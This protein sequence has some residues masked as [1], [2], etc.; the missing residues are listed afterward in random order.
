MIIKLLPQLAAPNMRMKAGLDFFNDQTMGL[1]VIKLLQLLFIG[2]K[3]V[4]DIFFLSL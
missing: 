1:K 3:N 4:V 2:G